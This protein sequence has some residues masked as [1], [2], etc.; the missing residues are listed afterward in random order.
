VL[1]RAPDA[2][3]LR[4]LREPVARLGAHLLCIDAGAT[5]PG[6]ATMREADGILAAWFDHHQCEAA[7]VRPDHLVYGVARR[8]GEAQALVQRACRTLAD[9]ECAG[10]G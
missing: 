8:L 5:V 2:A 4:A 7:L 10:P 9:S 3:A 6:V 1:R